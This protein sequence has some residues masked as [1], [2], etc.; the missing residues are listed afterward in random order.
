MTEKDKHF[1]REISVVVCA[2]NGENSIYNCI[3]SLAQQKGIDSS[4]YEVLLVDDESQDRTGTLLKSFLGEHDGNLPVFRYIKIQHRGLSVARNTGMLLAKSSLIAYIDQDAVADEYWIYELL[5]A[6]KKYP[7]AESI[8][9]RIQI[10]NPENRLAQL[11]HDAF[12]DESDKRAIIGTNMSFKRKRLLDIGGFC[13]LFVSRGDE[14]YLF[15]KMGDR[16]C[17]TEKNSTFIK[18]TDAVVYH[19]RPDKILKWLKERIINGKMIVLVNKALGIKN[20]ILIKYS[21][22]RLSFVIIGVILLFFVFFELRQLIVVILGI[23]L[24]RWKGSKKWKGIFTIYKNQYGI[25]QALY[26]G[27]IIAILEDLGNLMFSYGIAKGYIKSFIYK[28]NPN[29]NRCSITKE[30]IID[31][32][33]SVAL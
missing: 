9:G 21:F 14:T 32:M 3:M 22:K 28:E 24:I 33:D 16:F 8:G 27:Y 12:Y 23:L 13:D 1:N 18:W 17:N 31:E 26:A 11:L 6:W 7:D 5:K 2:Y 25:F 19:P 4:K 15:G 30:Y 10:L 29:Y 20:S